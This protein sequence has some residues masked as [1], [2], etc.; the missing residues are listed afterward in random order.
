[1][2]VINIIKVFGEVTDYNEGRSCFADEIKS[3]FCIV[4]VA[5]AGM[6]VSVGDSAP[7]YTCLT[8]VI[9][10]SFVDLIGVVFVNISVNMGRIHYVPLFRRV[11]I[12]L[13]RVI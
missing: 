4:Y 2:I 3:F 11:S 8:G 9:V 5:F 12:S 13:F 10:V 6:I 1:M 7:V